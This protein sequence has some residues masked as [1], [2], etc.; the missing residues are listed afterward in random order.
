MNIAQTL[1][2]LARGLVLPGIL[3]VTAACEGQADAPQKPGPEVDV[4]TLQ[5]QRVML[6]TELPGHTFAFR[7]A[8]VRA[9]VAATAVAHSAELINVSSSCHCAWPA[10]ERVNNHT[11]L[12][13]RFVHI[14]TGLG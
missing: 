4:M 6:V 12:Y 1:K 8:A 13:E 11:V 9:L 10:R 7:T 3:F 5:P 2:L 14:R